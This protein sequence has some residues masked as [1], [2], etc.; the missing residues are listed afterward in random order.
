M[1]LLVSSAVHLHFCIGVGFYR[2]GHCSSLICRC[3]G[4]LALPV[5]EVNFTLNM[6]VF[7]LVQY[8]VP[9]PLKI[10]FI[11]SS[12]TVLI[13]RNLRSLQGRLLLITLFLPVFRKEDERTWQMRFLPEPPWGQHFCSFSQF[14]WIDRKLGLAQVLQFF[15][16][17][18]SLHFILPW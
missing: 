4:L 10:G 6:R 16:H 8:L 12:S 13:S 7:Q 3:S 1:P 11:F 2:W 15:C 14:Q 18:N 5:P 17:F 9:C